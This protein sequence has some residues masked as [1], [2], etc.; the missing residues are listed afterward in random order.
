MRLRLN[1]FLERGI[2]EGLFPADL[3]LP[4][5]TEALLQIHVGLMTALVLQR[6]TSGVSPQRWTAAAV[7]I[8]VSGLTR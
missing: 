7:R 4:A 3:D 8:L 6:P 1:G 5:S 2:A